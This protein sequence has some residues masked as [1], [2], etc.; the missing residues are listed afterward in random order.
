MS[1]SSIITTEV[2]LAVVAVASLLLM[3]YVLPVKDYMRVLID[4]MAGLDI[5]TGSAV[6]M[7]VYAVTVVLFLPAMV[8]SIAAGFLWGF[9]RS[10]LLV[11]TGRRVQAVV[12]VCIQRRW[13]FVRVVESELHCAWLPDRE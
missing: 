11:T 12:F 6:F 3:C 8:L 2:K 13:T 9:W 4:W 7:F 10:L 5:F 1:S